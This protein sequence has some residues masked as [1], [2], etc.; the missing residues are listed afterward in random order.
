[1]AFPSLSTFHDC[2]SKLNIGMRNIRAFYHITEEEKDLLINEI[3]YRAKLHCNLYK[4]WP[5]KRRQLPILNRGQ[6]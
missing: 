6:I 2:L 1:M 3:D 5:S 4:Y